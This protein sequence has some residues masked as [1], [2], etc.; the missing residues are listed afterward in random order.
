MS[1]SET[2]LNRLKCNGENCFDNNYYVDHNIPTMTY[3]NLSIEQHYNVVVAFTKLIDEVK[4]DL[5][6]EIGTYK[7][8]LTKMLYDIISESST[9][10]CKLISY[11]VLHPDELVNKISNENL[12]IDFRYKNLFKDDYSDLLENSEL[13]E[14]ITSHN[15]VIVLCDGGSKIS[16][17]NSVSKYLKPND[18]IMAHDYSINNQIYQEKIHNKIWYWLE[19]QYHDIERSCNEYNLESYMEDIFNNVAWACK[20]KK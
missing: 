20:I 10:N 15:K 18:V 19:I 4:P 11:D 2:I 8:G 6:V 12:N 14:L 13:I 1:I 9:P 3:D 16:E 17:F 7:G 5:I